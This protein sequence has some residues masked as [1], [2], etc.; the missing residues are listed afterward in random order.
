MVLMIIIL[1][2][3]CVLMSIFFLGIGFWILSTRKPLL[4]AAHWHFGLIVLTFL[5]SVSLMV[6][7]PLKSGYYIYPLVIVAILA[8]VWIKMKGYI[9]Y[10]ITNDSFRTA[11]HS[12]LRQLNIQF[13]ESLSH[14]KL[15]ALGVDLQTSI[16]SWIGIGH[17]KVKPSKGKAVLRDI[18]KAII[19]YYQTNKMNANNVTIIVYIVIGVLMAA[20]AVGV[21]IVMGV[22]MAAS[23][24]SSFPQTYPEGVPKEIVSEKDLASMILIPTGEFRMGSRGEHLAREIKR[25]TYRR[26]IFLSKLSNETP[27]HVVYVDAFY[28]D[29]Y[30]VTNAQY[31]KFIEATGHRVPSYWDDEKFNHPNQPVVGVSWEDAVAYAKWA[32]KRLPTEAEWE[33]AARGTDGRKYPWG[34][35]WDSSKCNSNAGGDKYEFTAPVSNFPASASPY[36]VMDMAGNV[37]EWIY[38]WYDK[39]AYRRG[40]KRNPKGPDSGS[41]RVLRGGSWYDTNWKYLRCAGRP[42]GIPDSGTSFIG[43]RCAQDVTP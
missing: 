9:A 43:F 20:S 11:I 8:F 22:L 32:G 23:I 13:E 24:D 17:I 12:V 18:V 19:D 40:P 4:L 6:T 28:I 25:I 15:T 34:N 16:K 42:R 3:V 26:V 36:G 38:D 35:E 7:H 30:E 37:E 31:K 10:G 2:V 27:Q 33:K 29:K 1:S 41:M 14:I 39:A 21:Y 5:P